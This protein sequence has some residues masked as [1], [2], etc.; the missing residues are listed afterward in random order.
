MHTKWS[1]ETGLHSTLVQQEKRENWCVCRHNTA[2]MIRTKQ[3]RIIHTFTTLLNWIYDTSPHKLEM[4]GL[5]FRRFMG[6]S[7]TPMTT[8]NKMF[9]GFT[10]QLERMRTAQRQLFCIR[11]H[12][13]FRF[14]ILFSIPFKLDQMIAVIVWLG[15]TRRLQL[16]LDCSSS[17]HFARCGTITVTVMSR[18]T[19]ETR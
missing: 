13:G 2:P 5:Y 12:F 15:C 10:L 4:I 17:I 19:R 6:T 11:C 18:N 9:S 8:E 3:R 1:A 7:T 14:E 16:Y